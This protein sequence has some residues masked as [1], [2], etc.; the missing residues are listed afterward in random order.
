MSQVSIIK[1]KDTVIRNV[2]VVGRKVEQTKVE[3]H[4]VGTFEN[5]W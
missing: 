5:N 4:F 1:S 3:E 2:Q